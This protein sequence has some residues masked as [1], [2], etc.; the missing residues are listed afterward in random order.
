[1]HLKSYSLGKA[2]N[3]LVDSGKLK[4]LV[5]LNSNEVNWGNQTQDV[6]VRCR[7]DPEVNAISRRLNHALSRSRCL[8]NFLAT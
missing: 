4:G 5:Q 8:S 7:P 1:M 3:C 2:F 6:P